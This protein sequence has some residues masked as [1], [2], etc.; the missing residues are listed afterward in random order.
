MNPILNNY[1][2]ICIMIYR[3]EFIG[4][5]L[6]RDKELILGDVEKKPLFGEVR[7]D[8]KIIADFT[9]YSPLHNGHLHCMME[10]KK[11][12]S[13]GIFTAIVPGPFERSGRGLPYVMTR[14]ARADAAILVGADIVVEGPPMGIMGSGQYSLCLAKMFKSIDADYIPR[15]YKPFKE[16]DKILKRINQGFAVVPKPYKIV[17]LESKEILFDGKLDEDNY[18]I[19]SLSKS[20]KKIKF[21]FKNKFLFIKR[22]EGVSGTKIREAILN[23][24][25]KMVEDMLPLESI[26]ILNRE[27]NHLRAPLNNI[28]DSKT[29]L[30]RV[31]EDSME[32][33]ERLALIDNKT[34]NA[35]LLNRP[36]KNLDEIQN[37]I[38]QGFSR[39]YKQRILSSMEAGIF[40]DTIHKYIEN[41]PSV[42]RILNYKNNEVLKEFKK[43]IP[44]RRLEIC[45]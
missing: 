14:K 18:V 25:L 39:H 23:S 17:D 6:K 16:F 13:D 26:K 20:L 3:E 38:T 29:I 27:I 42:I 5:I 31:N 7:N 4:S 9:E 41:Y 33:I 22:V 32:D 21:D 37:L 10:A 40:K 44:H 15:G 8:V 1:I 45:Q 2:E 43:R 30:S 24:N 34:V 12:I 28:R 19:V 36:F 11:Q 35:L